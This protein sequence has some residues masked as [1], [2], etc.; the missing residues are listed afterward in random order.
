MGAI[1]LALA[2]IAGVSLCVAGIGIMNVMLVTVSERRSE[3]GLLKAIG[4]QRRQ[5]LSVFLAEAAM[6]SMAGGLAGLGAGWGAVRAFV[7]KYPTFP[8]SPPA[9]AVG[10]ALLLALGTGVFF[11]Y[12]PARQ[13]VRLDPVTALSG[14]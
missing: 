13:A 10:A 1:T 6:I 14:N 7:W 11:G 12:W 9:W 8:A 3:I 5:V 4:A 2:G